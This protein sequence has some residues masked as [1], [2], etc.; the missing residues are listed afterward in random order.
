[1]GM[2]ITTELKESLIERIITNSSFWLNEHTSSV[3]V[4][5]EMMRIQNFIIRNINYHASFNRCDFYTCYDDADIDNLCI[6]LNKLITA[7]ET[8]KD[9]AIFENIRGY[10]FG[11]LETDHGVI[12]VYQKDKIVHAKT[13]QSLTPG[14]KDKL[15]ASIKF[16]LWIIGNWRRDNHI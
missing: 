15:M 4:L 11:D 8:E 14:E 9:T 16:N 13:V 7:I 1:M 12:Q 3:K 2:I 6:A 5:T 10:I